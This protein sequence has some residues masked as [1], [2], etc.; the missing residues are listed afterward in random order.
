MS[1]ANIVN[2]THDIHYSLT[3]EWQEIIR[4]WND[5]DIQDWLGWSWNEVTVTTN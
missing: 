4:S 2:M 3:T 1:I 5:I